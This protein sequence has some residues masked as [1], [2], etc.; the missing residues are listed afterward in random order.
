MSEPEKDEN[1]PEADAAPEAPGPEAAAPDAPRPEADAP[2]APGPEADAAP[3]AP[4][5]QAVGAELASARPE[6][7]KSPQPDAAPARSPLTLLVDALSSYAL[8]VILLL[9]LF[10]LVFLGTIEQ[11]DHGLFEVQRKYFNSLGF[12]HW[13]ADTIPL[14]LPGVRLVLIVF[15][16]NMFFG[17]IVRLR[18]SKRTIGVLI[19]HLGIALLL[20]GGLMTFYLSR[21]GNLALRE[22]G[23]GASFHAYFVHELAVYPVDRE[24]LVATGTRE[25]LI[26]EHAFRAASPEAPAT[27][28]LEQTP[29]T[30]S[31][32]R[33]TR[34]ATPLLP[35]QR[36]ALAEGV[37]GPLGEV[38][39][40]ALYPLPLTKE[41]EANLPG[42]VVTITP[43]GAE[44]RRELLWAGSG[45]PL[46]LEHEGKLWAFELRKERRNLPFVVAL[47]TFHHEKHPGTGMA[48][49]FKSDVTYSDPERGVDGK[50]TIAMNEPLR[51][52]GY[53]LYQA[54][55]VEQAEGNVSIFAVVE[56]PWG[57]W[58]IL[59]GSTAVIGIGLSLHFAL[60]LYGYIKSQQRTRE[61]PQ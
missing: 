40:A 44:P 35:H 41:A 21:E 58:W 42:V 53:T 48:R 51:Y 9:T 56:T 30:V 34:N 17:G 23:R 43:A 60:K 28:A 31:F 1:A 10:L 25:A 29:F 22:G 13:I 49:A 12:V 50:I 32:E 27:F 57:Q 20:L 14:P 45:A 3:E 36:A 8:A 52:R 33:Y 6:V 11:I 47:D 61:R 19:T 38:R 2:D 24:G 7:A 5:P 16:V 39:G 46:V 26:A 37:A 4:G 54:K 18:K 55:F 59:V 15:A